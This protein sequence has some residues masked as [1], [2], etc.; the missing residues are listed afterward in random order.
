MTYITSDNN[1]CRSFNLRFGFFSV[2]YQDECKIVKI[3]N[4]ENEIVKNESKNKKNELRK[5]EKKINKKIEHEMKLRNRKN[6]NKIE[7]NNKKKINENKIEIGLKI[8]EKM[9]LIG[10]A[11][12]GLLSPSKNYLIRET[13][14]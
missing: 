7:K 4:R 6:E 1:K 3:E 11:L 12:A 2:A 10:S 5:I 14:T 8:I 13:I 9:V